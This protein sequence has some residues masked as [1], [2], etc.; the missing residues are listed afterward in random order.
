MKVGAK[1][2]VY[3]AFRGVRRCRVGV[4]AALLI[5][6]GC[7]SAQG[8]GTGEGDGAA[9]TAAGQ[10]APS[11]ATRQVAPRPG[12]GTAWV[13]FGADTVVA[14]VA[15]T[16]D[17]R[18]QGLMYRDELPDGTG[19]LFIFDRSEIQSFWMSNT[20]VALDIA[21]IGTSYNVIDIQ[22]ME[23]LTT[24]PHESSGP[25]LFALEVPQGWFAEHGVEVGDVAQ[26][27]FGI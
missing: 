18:A 10:E 23:P 24:T 7:G 3:K 26:V 6:S 21:Y 4:L 12:P 16:A 17:E 20:Y 1:A 13:I 19:M 15:R 22:Q 2:K 5:I 11:T 9:A 27:I 14:E 25:A 8:E